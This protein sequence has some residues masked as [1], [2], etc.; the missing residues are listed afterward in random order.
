M[1]KLLKDAL[2]PIIKP[3]PLK[4]GDTVAVISPAGPA[5]EK[6]L[7]AGIRR[8]ERWGFSVRPGRHA[9]GR[10]TYL[11]AADEERFSDLV[12]AFEDPSVK[13]VFCSRG[14]YG[15]GRL[16][17][18]I[19]FSL[20]AKNPKLFVGFSDVTALNWAF[21]ARSGLISLS[22]PTVCELG[23]GL[24]D[25]AALSLLRLIG[26]RE[27]SETLWKGGLKRLRPGAARGVLFPGCLSIIVTL[28]GTPYLPDLAGAVL[29]IE[30]VKE[31]PYRIDRMLTQLK[32]AGVLN[33]IAALLVGEMKNCWPKTRRRDHLS[34][35]EILLELTSDHPIPVFT[36]APYGHSRSRV[37][38]PV[39][40]QV[41][42]SET[43]GLRLLEDPLHLPG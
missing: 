31:E 13:A 7:R 34:L 25:D 40:A 11:A 35:D 41:E 9:F 39:G 14:G 18:R 6:R 32:N 36:G 17:S 30:D 1:A 4:P 10:R 8:L 26:M 24:P 2:I 20:I 19:P 23:D 16:L 37:T 22:G 29:L 5:D 12:A 27:E 3:R 21:S 42:V 43:G 33:R 15:S 38:L 28:L